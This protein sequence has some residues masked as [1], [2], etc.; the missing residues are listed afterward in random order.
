MQGEVLE[1]TESV[2]LGLVR[3]AHIFRVTQQRPRRWGLLPGRAQTQVTLSQEVAGGAPPPPP[4][5]PLPP[6]RCMLGRVQAHR[7][8]QLPDWA[9]RP[10]NLDG[11]A[12][13]QRN[14]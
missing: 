11:Q 14:T 9:D 1:W 3:G 8:V 4:P 10:P 13:L 5:P 7:Q 12:A 2:A 6:L